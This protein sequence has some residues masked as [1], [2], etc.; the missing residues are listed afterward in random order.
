[1]VMTIRLL[2]YCMFMHDGTYNVRRDGRPVSQPD[3]TFCSELRYNSL[4]SGSQGS[5]HAT[6]HLRGQVRVRGRTIASHHASI[7]TARTVVSGWWPASLGFLA[8]KSIG[9]S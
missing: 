8:V 3:L 4:F 2:K 1:M 5:T 7:V 9:C 6:Q